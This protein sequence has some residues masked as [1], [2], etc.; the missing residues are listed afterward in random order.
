MKETSRPAASNIHLIIPINYLSKQKR[1]QQPIEQLSG[2]NNK[3]LTSAIPHI[4]IDTD[5]GDLKQQTPSPISSIEY[6][7]LY[8]IS[9]YLVSS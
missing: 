3:Y 7:C 1:Q 5:L 9:P 2:N 8:Q 6:N 4:K